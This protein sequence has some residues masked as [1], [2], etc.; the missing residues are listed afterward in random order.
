MTAATP[1]RAG[2]A[3]VYVSNR[4]GRA[5]DRNAP[6]YQ[7]SPIASAAHVFHQR[8]GAR[9]ADDG[10]SVSGFLL[11]AGPTQAYAQLPYEELTYSWLL[12]KKRRAT[13]IFMCE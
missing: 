6:C 13:L 11:F 1:S 9:A 5:G 3:H 12:K 7:G 4:G 2:P 8:Q 10:A